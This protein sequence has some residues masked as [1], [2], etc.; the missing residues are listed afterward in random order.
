MLLDFFLKGFPALS[1]IIYAGVMI[2]DA[3][4]FLDKVFAGMLNYARLVGYSQE[5]VRVKNKDTQ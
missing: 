3:R 4:K 2:Y 1:E 5:T